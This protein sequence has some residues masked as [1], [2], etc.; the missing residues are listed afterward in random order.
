MP[1]YKDAAGTVWAFR[2][3]IVPADQQQFAQQLASAV[4]GLAGEGMFIVGLSASGAEPATHYVSS[5]YIGEQFAYLL[6]LDTYTT[7]IDPNT[8]QPVVV[9]THKD[10]D[11][12]IVAQLALQGGLVATPEQVTA[13]FDASDITEQEPFTAFERLGLQLVQQPFNP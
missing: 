3:L 10:G 2:T 1:T 8:G 7:E 13:L 11:P 12:I 6:P 4:G 9:H 5:G